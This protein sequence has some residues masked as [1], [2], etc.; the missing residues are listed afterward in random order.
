M[1]SKK[2]LTCAAMILVF[3]FSVTGWSEQTSQAPLWEDTGPPPG[4][5]F[6]WYEPSFYT[7]FAPR[8]QEPER[9]HIRLGRGNQTRIT[10]VL[11]VT[12][13]DSYLEDLVTRDTVYK[14]LIDRKIIELTQNKEYEKF[15]SRIQE[16]DI[17]KLV[18]QKKSMKPDDYRTKSLEIMRSLNPNRVFHFRQPLSLILK[19]WQ[20][21]IMD[22][23][24]IEYSNQPLK[25][26]LVNS[27]LPG[28]I[29]LYNLTPEIEMKLDRMISAVHEINKTKQSQDL[30]L[31]EG[32][33]FLNHVTGRHYPVREGF[34]DVYEFTTIY[35]TG[36]AKSWVAYRGKQLPDFSV[37]G[38][39]PFIPRSKGKGLVGMVDYLSS[40]PGYGYITMLPYQH[41]GGLSYNAY[42]NTGVRCPL[43]GSKIL[44]VTWQKAPGIRD[45]K[46]PY[47]NLWI[48]SRGPVSHGC[49]RLG[50]GHMSE[51]RN[52]LPSASKDLE[53]IDTFRNLPQCYDIFDINGDG[54]E[55]VMG[56]KYYLAYAHTEDRVPYMVYATN[57]REPFYRWLYAGE[58]HM[59]SDGKALFPQAL[60]CQFID[61]KAIEGE[62]YKN[63][64]LWEAEYEPECIQF[65]R[66]RPFS[67]ESPQGFEFNREL[68]RVGVGYQVDGKKLQLHEG[69]SGK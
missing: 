56:V 26:K 50:S 5:Y 58:L 66:F 24:E 54:L 68:R 12:Q 4:I 34:V 35:P 7:G 36:T 48:I 10:V 3:I 64:P 16:E 53:K 69:T 32:E 15:E 18:E 8:C 63:I 31:K 27:M 46:R 37:T 21:K 6:Y 60:S 43:A 38:I 9:I 19:N 22:I 52:L 29:N 1:K 25:L 44:P 67:F 11:G 40:N 61:K 2:P 13:I 55:E 33:D 49:T 65:Y 30:F 39:W 47:Q 62:Y 59:D 23:P 20:Q 28:R 41:A 42:H 14:E 17:Q 45:P 57:K 51:M